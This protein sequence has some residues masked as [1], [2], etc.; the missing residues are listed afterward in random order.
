M[1]K[2]M[3]YNRP[4]KVGLTI[5]N[6]MREEYRAVSIRTV[7]SMVGVF[8]VFTSFCRLILARSKLTL[9]V[10]NELLR[11]PYPHLAIFTISRFA[12]GS[13]LVK[14]S[15]DYLSDHHG[16]Y[17][18]IEVYYELGRSAKLEPR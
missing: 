18:Y 16:T 17:L 4:L 14:Q 9:G 15:S 10:K 1:K 12:V 13:L 3:L 5:H 8:G 6:T 11:M 7:R 2:L